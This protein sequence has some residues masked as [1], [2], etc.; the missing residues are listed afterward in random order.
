MLKS[1][2]PIENINTSTQ[3]S[4]SLIYINEILNFKYHWTYILNVFKDDTFISEQSRIIDEC[5][6]LAKIKRFDT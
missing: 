1:N 4:I 2:C 6:G 3:V 5:C